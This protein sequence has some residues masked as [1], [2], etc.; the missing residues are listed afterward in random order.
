MS[1]GPVASA[2][3]KKSIKR[4]EDAHDLINA[5]DLP[6]HTYHE[7]AS[8][9]EIVLHDLRRKISCVLICKLLADRYSSDP[10]I[11]LPM[12]IPAPE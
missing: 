5:R 10:T 11:A 8:I 1:I 3:G 2:L 7:T 9:I 6:E 4:I 12:Y